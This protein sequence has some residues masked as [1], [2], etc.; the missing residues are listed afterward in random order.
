[1]RCDLA[2][3]HRVIVIV[4]QIEPLTVCQLL[5]PCRAH[6]R[7]YPPDLLRILFEQFAFGSGSEPADQRRI[8]RKAFVTDAPQTALRAV[9]QCTS[10]AA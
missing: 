9:D 2:H 1:M 10:F 7:Q 4:F 5:I 6:C 8:E 3:S